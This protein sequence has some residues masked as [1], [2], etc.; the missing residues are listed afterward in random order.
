MRT[1]IARISEH[2]ENF[3]EQLLQFIPDLLVIIIIVLSG[4]IAAALVNRLLQKGFRAVRF[5]TWS[6][7]IGLTTAFRKAGITNPPSR[8]IGSFIYWFIIVLFFVAG[9]ATLGFRVTDALVSVFFLYLPR[10]FSAVI[11]VLLG[12]FIANFLA[13]AVLI[14]GVNSGI[15][16]SKALSELVRILL[17]VLA[18]AMALEQLAIAPKI[19]LAAFVIFFGSIGLAVAVAFGMAGRSYAKKALDFLLSRRDGNNLDQ[20]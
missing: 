3:G 8:F 20:L 5:D 10:F 15:E 11:I 9:F 6:D 2:L 4:F 12:Y 18:F 19:V 17:L 1:I 7:Q 13:R 16:Y 14:A